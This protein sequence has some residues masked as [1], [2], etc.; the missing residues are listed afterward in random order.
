M[1]SIKL[2]SMALGL[3]LA[4]SFVVNAQQKIGYVSVDAIVGNLPEI[5]DVQAK[6]DKFRIDSLGGEYDRLAAEISR[7]DSIVKNTTVK[8]VKETAQK[9]LND[10]V[11]TQAN[12]NNIA[13]E[14]FQAKQ[15]EL[16]S[17]LY[18]KAM[19]AVNAVAK[20][21]NYAYILDPQALIV[22]PPGD[23][24]TE[25]VATKLGIKLPTNPNAA[26]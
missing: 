15:G 23:N 3:V 9:D 4:T 2:L 21:K 26:K 12:W 6:L 1:K 8:Q 24:I 25:A 10:L 19:D 17:P 16:L 22:A 5:K 18:K 20:E 11:M 7:K 14:A 13:N